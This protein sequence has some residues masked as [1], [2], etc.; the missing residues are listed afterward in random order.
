MTYHIHSLN[1]WQGLW[2]SGYWYYRPEMP[3]DKRQTPM[4]FHKVKDIDEAVYV[5]HYWKEHQIYPN[6]ITKSTSFDNTVLF[7]FDKTALNWKQQ[8]NEE[9]NIEKLKVYVLLLSS[10]ECIVFL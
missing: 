4:F 8:S 9:I 3:F 10:T 2:T 6:L 5:S 1:E 7:L